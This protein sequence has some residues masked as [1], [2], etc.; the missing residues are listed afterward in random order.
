MSILPGWARRDTQTG[1]GALPPWYGVGGARGPSTGSTP[2]ATRVA[3]PLQAPRNIT[4]GSPQ[5]VGSGFPQQKPGGGAAATPKPPM[6]PWIND[7]PIYTDDSSQEQSII[8]RLMSQLDQSRSDTQSNLNARLGQV[9]NKDIER[10]TPEEQKYSRSADFGESIGMLKDLAKTGGYSDL[11][12]AALRERGVSPIRS[13]YAN[14]QRNLDRQKSIQGGYAPGFASAASRMAREQSG[15]LSDAVTK[16]NADIA[17]RVAKGKL[18]GMEKYAGMSEGENELI[19]K[20]LGGNV[21]RGTEA[22]RLN[23]AS[24]NEAML[25]RERL[26]EAALADA[27]KSQQGFGDQALA[28]AQ[29]RDKMLQASRGGRL[30]ERNTSRAGQLDWEKLNQQG[31]TALIDALMSQYGGR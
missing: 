22:K 1:A 17:D 19:N 25:Q 28:V 13:V 3:T 6:N 11:D 4:A 31:G 18:A 2:L 27:A 26:R 7:R 12:L 10:Y 9:G 20:I 5:S 15:M 21:E 23:A 16:V 30:E 29:L 24:A 14:A 8:D